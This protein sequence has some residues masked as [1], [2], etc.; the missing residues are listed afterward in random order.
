MGSQLADSLEPCQSSRTVIIEAAER[1][2]PGA[3]AYGKKTEVQRNLH[4]RFLNLEWT[5]RQ[6]RELTG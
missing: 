5:R 2:G 4:Q 1:L 3:V 6:M